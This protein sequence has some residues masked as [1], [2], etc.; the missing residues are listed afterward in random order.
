MARRFEHLVSYDSPDDRRRARLLGSVRGFGV[1]PQY[2]FHECLLAPG[3]RSELWRRL[4]A[5]AIP[6][7]R[8]L[9]LR[10]SPDAARWRFAA[11]PALSGPRPPLDYVG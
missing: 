1:D 3:E 6:G 9:F 11:P 4:A 10:L 8:L 5:G 2:S 7:D